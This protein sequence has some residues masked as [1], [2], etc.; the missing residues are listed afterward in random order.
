MQALMKQ[1]TILISL[2]KHLQLILLHSITDLVLL[3]ITITQNE[4]FKINNLR[5]KIKLSSFDKTIFFY[6]YKSNNYSYV[7][8][9]FYLLLEILLSMN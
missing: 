2:L 5:I 7:L 1:F 6:I 9:E 3:L 4:I 8:S